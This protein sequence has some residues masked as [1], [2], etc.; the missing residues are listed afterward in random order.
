MFLGIVLVAYISAGEIRE[1]LLYETDYPFQ[2]FPLN[3]REA[4]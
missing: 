3:I 1:G 4:C 2:L